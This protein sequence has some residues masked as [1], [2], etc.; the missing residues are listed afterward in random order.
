MKGKEMRSTRVFLPILFILSF[1]FMAYAQPGSGRGEGR[2]WKADND[3]FPGRHMNLPNLTDEQKEQIAKL[4]TENMKAMQDS[5]NLM[6]EKM[7][8]LHTLQT[9]DK[10]DMKSINGLI[11]EIAGIK[12]TMAKTQAAHHQK[13]RSLL[14]D[15]QRVI[16]DSR[17][18]HGRGEGFGKGHRG[19]G[20][21]DCP[22]RRD[23]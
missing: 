11:D 15:E 8:R 5:R 9:A 23:D 21:G 1:V 16:F 22:C 14:T 18:H 6:Q 2:G 12:A 10:P 17:P 7:A 4:R 3:G 13:I 19:K 20:R